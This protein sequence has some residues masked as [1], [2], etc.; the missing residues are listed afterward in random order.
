MRSRGRWVL[1]ARHGATSREEAINEAKT[2]QRSSK[3]DAVR[4]V[5][6]M[7]NE[8]TGNSREYPVYED[9]PPTATKRAADP[10]DG[11]MA[12]LEEAFGP[13]DFDPSDADDER[14]GRRRGGR[15][16]L[17]GRARGL[18]PLQSGAWRLTAIVGGSLAF[19]ILLTLVTV[20]TIAELPELRRMIGLRQT[21]YNVMLF[22]VFILSFGIS[23]GVSAYWNFSRLHSAMPAGR[24][25]GASSAI[26]RPNRGARVSGS[27]AAVDRVSASQSYASPGRQG[28]LGG[29]RWGDFFAPWR[30]IGR[31]KEMAEPAGPPAPPSEPLPSPDAELPPLDE[32]VEEV[33]EDNDEAPPDVTLSADAER[34]KSTVLNFL[35]QGLKI[36]HATQPTLDRF[37]VLGVHLY[38]AGAC[39]FAGTE[40]GL[41]DV[42]VTQILQDGVVL[43]GTDAQQAHSFASSLDSYLLEPKYLTMIEAGRAAME[44]HV[45][46]LDA[47][48]QLRDALEVWNGSV[49]A[50]APTDTIAV[51]F[52]NDDD[53][54]ELTQ[55]HGEEVAQ[56]LVRLH[57]RVVRDSLTIHLGHEIKHQGSGIM[58]SFASARNAV[59]AAVDIQEKIAVHN[60]NA[61]IPLRLKIGIHAGEPVAEDGDLY[62]NTVQVA[63]RIA[64][65]ADPGAVLVSTI[66]SSLCDGTAFEFGDQASRELDSIPD[67]VEL[68]EVTW[69]RPDTTI[70][71]DDEEPPEIPSEPPS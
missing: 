60:L 22:V 17:P 18:S 55:T 61:T 54:L 33:D 40:T 66:V 14:A 51:L 56:E 20:F 46:G 12:A 1:H 38:L 57:T 42:E 62:G 48:L 39:E 4:V 37:N 69:N 27:V 41:R 53:V 43:L 23:L 44:V 32:V 16:A 28:G 24:S 29:I 35:I 3:V 10:D 21:G 34:Q 47:S 52:T 9:P 30:W 25:R 49:A 45:K 13:V 15:K 70:P 71:G 6:E 50:D 7:Y 58:A 68:C 8:A 64:K 2:L 31:R 63:E 11:D 26:P 36:V 19:A 59:G 65:S 67:P 5:R